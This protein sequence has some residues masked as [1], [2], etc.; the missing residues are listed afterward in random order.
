MSIENSQGGEFIDNGFDQ[1]NQ[2]EDFN[3]FED[4]NRE[5]NQVS[6][7]AQ[8]FNDYSFSDDENSEQ[9]S[10][11]DENWTQAIDDDPRVSQSQRNQDEDSDEEGEQNQD[12]SVD[13]TQVKDFTLDDILN[14]GTGEDYNEE[15]EDSSVVV[16]N[17]NLTVEN[18]I[19][20]LKEKGL[21]V[22]QPKDLNAVRVQ[23]IGQL[24]N[25]I[26]DLT[27]VIN[28]PDSEF[29]K[30]ALRNEL[31]NE[32]NQSGR[33]N[34][35]NSEEFEDSLTD[36]L[37]ELEINQSLKRMVIQN[38]KLSL[39][40]F[41]GGKKADLT[42]LEQENL[43]AK[44]QEVLMLT[45]QRLQSIEKLTKENGLSLHDA[46]KALAFIKSDEYKSLVNNSDFIIQSV[47]AELARRDGK[48]LFNNDNS[49]GRGVNDT[50]EEIKKNGSGRTSNSQLTNQMKGSQHFAASSKEIN[51]WLTFNT[52]GNVVEDK[53][54]NK[55]RAAGM[56]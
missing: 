18:A 53:N 24:N 23:E 28:M 34:L 56:M 4:D 45:N 31:V 36:Q 35:I 30:V 49:Y 38:H 41:I 43:K 3:S 9:E 13:N 16:D 29:L 14:Q 50:L 51:P 25:T 7:P 44:E 5:E 1:D 6:S 48:K 54:P 15:N 17:Q 55:K 47:F 32:Y 26:S 10:F 11:Q 22:E 20:F 42:R 46:Q 21:N 39:S 33:T 40:N 27:R 2:S 12:A 19:S 52:G 8:T 37:D